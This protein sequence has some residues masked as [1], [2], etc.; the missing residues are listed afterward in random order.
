MSEAHEFM[1]ENGA[2]HHI[3][4]ARGVTTTL[5]NRPRTQTVNAIA[6]ASRPSS[7][8]KTSIVTTQA[9][10][11]CFRDQWLPWNHGITK[12]STPDDR[13]EFNK[14]RTYAMHETIEELFFYD[15]ETAGMLPGYKRL[16]NF[17]GIEPRTTID[18]C[19]R[20]L[21]G[22]LVNIVDL[23]DAA[24][25]GG[26]V[27][28]WRKSEWLSFVAHTHT[29]GFMFQLQVASES[30]IL[31]CF[32]QDLDKAEP[33]CSGNPTPLPGR[34]LDAS[35][36]Q[37]DEQGREDSQESSEEGSGLSGDDL[38]PSEVGSYLSED[39]QDLSGDGSLPASSPLPARPSLRS[40]DAPTRNRTRLRGTGRPAVPPGKPPRGR[41]FPGQQD[42]T[43]AQAR[44][45]E[46]S[47]RPPPPPGSVVIDIRDG[48]P[49]LE[50]PPSRAAATG[51][52]PARENT[53]VLTQRTPRPAEQ[54]GMRQTHG[55]TPKTGLRQSQVDAFFSSAA[56]STTPTTLTGPIIYNCRK[57]GRGF[58]YFVHWGELEPDWTPASSLRGYK[59]A[60]IQFH[61]A[62]PEADSTGPDWLLS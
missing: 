39:D 59:E 22:T 17:I 37:L 20:D 61:L 52:Q 33:H 35:F 3:P 42:R 46:S 56:R 43:W 57:A 51:G 11:Q 48:T 47:I 41:S 50:P 5:S 34:G 21:R 36:F 24:G 45:A 49:E 6:P 54:S 44:T 18:R 28:V 15:Q 12:N 26:K 7:T 30:E 8:Q 1:K 25:V 9:S 23:L 19:R 60:L 53:M 31:S 16:C 55:T 2:G 32:L 27:R 40:E 10:S 4:K 29:P 58:S 13:K 38:T 62:H 14:K